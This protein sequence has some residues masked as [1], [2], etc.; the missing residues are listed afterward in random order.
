MIDI[1]QFTLSV[2]RSAGELIVQERTGAT[3]SSEFKHGIE[4]VTSADLKAD[5]L[6]C[7]RIAQQ[8]PHHYILSEESSPD[9]GNI[10]ELETP[11]WI[12]DP[13]DGTVNYAHGHNQSAISIA[14]VENKQIRVGVVFNP[15]T[16]E[17]FSAKLGGGAF[18]NN[19][20]IQVATES[21]LERAIIATG[22]PYDK[23]ALEPII[24]RLHVVLKDCADIRRIGSAALD[25]C[26]LAMGRLDGYYESLSL[27][28][29]AAAGLIAREAGAEYG[30]FSTVPAGIDPYSHDRDI[31]VANPILFPKLRQLLQTADNH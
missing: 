21:E 4:L 1:L 19:S 31:L 16:D 15:F 29:F 12:V 18:L 3:L 20:P 11:G 8:F 25:I 6:I 7:E 22:F 5:R 30:H 27:W 14:Y 23:S 17:M 13:I 26:W 9:L 10:Q 24:N 2:A 28:D